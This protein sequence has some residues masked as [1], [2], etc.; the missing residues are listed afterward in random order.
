MTKRV[1]VIGAGRWGQNHIGTLAELGH[2]FGIVETNEDVRER[3]SE[4]YPNVRVFSN[5]PDSLVE[6]FDG[7]TVAT[8]AETHYDIARL[9]IEN[10][11][12]VLVEKPLA[13]TTKHAK[14]LQKTAR[15]NGVNLMVG[16]VL[17]FHPAIRKIKELIDSGKIGK[18]QYL[19]SNRLNLAPGADPVTGCAFYIRNYCLGF[20]AK[21]VQ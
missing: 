19:Y 8:P 16:H 4:S 17:L 7:Y 13:L 6:D 5:V 20:A 1:C 9:I 11:R 14:E 15:D 10:K 3:L 2:L 18:L 12:H 21:A